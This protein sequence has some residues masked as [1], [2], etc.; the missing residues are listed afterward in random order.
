MAH[1]RH[2]TKYGLDTDTGRGE[3]WTTQAECRHNPDA[4]FAGDGQAHWRPREAL[5]VCRA[6]CPVLA[7]C[8]A[9]AQTQTP[10]DRVSLILGGVAYDCK[11][12]PAREG[13][14]SSMPITCAGCRGRSPMLAAE[15]RRHGT[16][17]AVRWHRDNR[18]ALCPDCR[19]GE[20]RRGS[21]RV[22][23][24]TQRRIEGATAWTS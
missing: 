20:R 4:F 6:H 13:R 19:I 5:H 17:A 1:T 23:K 18:Q 14:W 9:Y 24:R 22:R 7:Q 11:G 3:H 8:G 10:A 15:P 12:L 21:D 2:G 16:L